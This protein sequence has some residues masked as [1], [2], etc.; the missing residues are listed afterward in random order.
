[1][2]VIV[3]LRWTLP[4][5][6]V[7]QMMALCWKYLV[8]AAFACFVFT[9]LW[10]LAGRAVPQLELVSGYVLTALA[11]LLVALFVRQILRNVRAVRGDT[12]DLSNW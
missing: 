8:P 4:R 11:V 9:L 12:V 7:D 10:M 6:R 1:V 5:I 3:W 2:N